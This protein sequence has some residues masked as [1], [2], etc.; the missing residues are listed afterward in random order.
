[1]GTNGMEIFWEKFQEIRK[2]LH[3]RKT[4]HSTEN[5]IP[6]IPGWKSVKWN[7]NF[8]E[9]SF[10]NFGIPHEVVLFFGIYANFKFFTQRLASSFGR[11]HSEL[12]ISR[13]DDGDAH[14]IKETL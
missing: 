8:Q 13:K 2:L 3:F 10:E 11:D 5:Q 1:M 6:E 12:D 9:K 4:N 7:V 14:S